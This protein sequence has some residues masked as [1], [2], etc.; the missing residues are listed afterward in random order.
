MITGHLHIQSGPWLKGTYQSVRYHDLAKTAKLLFIFP[1]PFLLLL[2]LLHR[3]ECGKVLCH[4]YHSHMMSVGKQYTDYVVVVSWYV[5]TGPSLGS[6]TCAYVIRK[7]D[8]HPNYSPYVCLSQLLCSGNFLGT[9]KDLL[10]I[11]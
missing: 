1:F 4:K 5:Y 3:K 10:L 8:V 6:H 11:K 7:L 2:D 9:I